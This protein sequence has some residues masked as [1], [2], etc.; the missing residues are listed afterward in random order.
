MGPE[1]AYLTISGT[2]VSTVSHGHH[3]FNSHVAESRV[4]IHQKEWGCK[5]FFN[6]EKS[7]R[8]IQGFAKV[9]IPTKDFYCLTG[10]HSMWN[11]LVVL[12]PR[13]VPT[14]NIHL[15]I[16][17][18][19]VRQLSEQGDLQILNFQCAILPCIVGKLNYSTQVLVMSSGTAWNFV[20]FI[21]CKTQSD[22][23][24]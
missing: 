2:K 22:H 24:N 20:S 1:L 6:S 13:Q 8:A 23:Q 7:G 9:S 16:L 3:L 12:F 19:V 4:C 10:K 15:I 21:Y 18:F 5:H 11:N 17:G 14:R